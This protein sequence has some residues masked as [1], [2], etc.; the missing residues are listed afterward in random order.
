MFVKIIAALKEIQEIL[1]NYFC[2]GDQLMDNGE[3]GMPG[4]IAVKAVAEVRK[5]AIESA[6]S[7]PI[8]P[9]AKTARPARHTKLPNAT[10]KLVQVR[11]LSVSQM[12]K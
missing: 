5:F 8:Y 3:T 12:L 7:H 4:M 2:F 1:V 9:K 11:R 10:K 6:S